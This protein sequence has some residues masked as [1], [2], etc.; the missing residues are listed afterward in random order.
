MANG[1]DKNLRDAQYRKSL[2]IAWFNANNAA[3][4]LLK[5]LGLSGT[6]LETEIRKWREWFLGEHRDYYSKT[7][8]NVGVAYRA[9]DTIKKLEAA[10]NYN[11]LSDVWME[12]S[13]DER[14]D[15]EILKKVAELQKQPGY[16]KP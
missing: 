9:E 10:K 3:I 4:E 7:I 15:G 2:S 12:M 13:A 1:E 5:G 8:A 11:E 14:R 16:E 6:V